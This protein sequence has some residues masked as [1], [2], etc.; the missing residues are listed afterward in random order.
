[1]PS[2]VELFSV[3]SSSHWPAKFMTNWWARGSASMRLTCAL[4]HR[5]VLQLALRRQADKLVIGNGAPQKEGQAAGQIQVTDAI[6]FTGLHAGRSVFG[7]ED[8]FGMR[9]N[10]FQCAFDAVFEI[11]IVPARLIEAQQLFRIG[12]A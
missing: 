10:E 5:G 6:G 3:R 4:Q 2:G 7:A 8:K 1:M 11:A 9:Q 12:I